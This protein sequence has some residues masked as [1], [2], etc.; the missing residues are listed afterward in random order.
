MLLLLRPKKQKNKKKKKWRFLSYPPRL[1]DFHCI[2]PNFISTFFIFIFLWMVKKSQKIHFFSFLAG[3][4]LCGVK[5]SMVHKFW[6]WCTNLH[7]R[8]FWGSFFPIDYHCCWIL[9]LKKSDN[10]DPQFLRLAL[11]LLPGML[12]HDGKH[13]SA[14]KYCHPYLIHKH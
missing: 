3:V 5:G 13:I 10:S 8:L 6:F 9:K 14:V 12:I 2:F 1:L 7:S 4:A 11:P